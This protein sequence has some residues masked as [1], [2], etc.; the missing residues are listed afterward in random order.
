MENRYDNKRFFHRQ[1]HESF[2]LSVWSF[3]FVHNSFFRLIVIL[4]F[5]PL[6]AELFYTYFW[7]SSFCFILL[8]RS[9]RNIC[10]FMIFSYLNQ[11]KFFMA[12]KHQVNERKAEMWKALTGKACGVRERVL[13]AFPLPS[14][15]EKRWNFF[16]ISQK[17][18]LIFNIQPVCGL[19]SA[20]EN[21]L[22]KFTIFN[23]GD[24]N[25]MKIRD[26]WTLS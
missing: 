16:G 13:F 18:H 1:V 14:V 7:R 12:H 20:V 23:H 4:C 3:L 24:E 2:N 15:P 11:I 9:A 10:Q 6:I 21:I 25:F 17:K 26:N 22:E 5:D 8:R 19:P